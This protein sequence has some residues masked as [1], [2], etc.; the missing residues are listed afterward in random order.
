MLFQNSALQLKGLSDLRINLVKA[1][2]SSP[3]PP[4]AVARRSIDQLSRHVRLLGKFFRRVQ[5]L[6]IPQFVALPMCSSVIM[7][8]WDKIVEATNAPSAMTSG[9]VLHL[10]NEDP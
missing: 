8:Y 9:T 10:K 6:N 4:D 5:Q 1:L 7:Y 3:T 2:H